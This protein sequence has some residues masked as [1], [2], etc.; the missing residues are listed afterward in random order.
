[1]DYRSWGGSL[2]AMSGSILVG[3]LLMWN[4]SVDTPRNWSDSRRMSSWQPATRTPGHSKRQPGRYQLCS[5]WSRTQL[6][7][8]S[9]RIWPDLAATPPGSRISSTAWPEL[10][11]QIAPAVTRVAVLRDPTVRGGIGQLGAIHA[12]DRPKSRPSDHPSHPKD[13]K[14][15]G[16]VAAAADRPTN[17]PRTAHSREA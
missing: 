5:L 12:G 6:A 9:S 4:S 13:C 2:D 10:L 11:K 8:A 1:M 7:S 15:V 17:R 3:P 16:V 14:A